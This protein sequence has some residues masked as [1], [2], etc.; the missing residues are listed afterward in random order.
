MN[1]LETRK[2]LGFTLDIFDIREFKEYYDSNSSRFTSFARNAFLKSISIPPSYFLEQPDETQEELLC[3]KLNL[4]NTQKKY[5][6]FSILVISLD[7][8]IL[9]ATKIKTNEIETRF[10]AIASI[11]EVKNIVWNRSLIKDGYKCGYLVCGT[12]TGKF[13]RTL[14]IDLPILFNKPTIIHEGFLKLASPDMPVEKDMIYYTSSKEVDFDDYQH[15]QLA[16][17][18]TMNNMEQIEDYTQEEKKNVLREPLE[19]LC[20]LAEEKVIPKNFIFPI[21][22]YMEKTYH[23]EEGFN[24]LTTHLIL[25]TLMAFDNNVKNIKQLNALLNAKN[26]IDILYKEDWSNAREKEDEDT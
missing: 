7:N 10:E 25:E 16:I 8:Q 5:F 23:I 2:L 9:N 1:T 22:S 4:V 17:E 15:I 21:Q 24:T 18:D 19:V 11:E 13:N 12:K 26:N 3:N 6:G 14:F 20:N